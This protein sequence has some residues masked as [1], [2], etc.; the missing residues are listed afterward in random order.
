[1]NKGLISGLVLLSIGLV[2]GILLS[3]VNYFTAPIIKE[4]EDQIKYEAL[5]E[6]YT[7][8]DYDISEVEGTDAFGT[9]FV[10]KEKGT[11]NIEAI[12]YTV[13]AQGYSD[14]TK[15]EMLI[16]VNN[17][18]SVQDYKV[19][20]HQETTGFGADIVDNDF[21]VSEIDDLGSFDAVAGVTKTS[22]AI[23]QCFTLVSERIVADL[24][25]GLD[26]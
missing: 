1:M 20:T 16:A 18:L 17:D 10:L 12:V 7:I 13:R 6:F 25:G 19:V 5:E 2:C 22:N 14:S 26:E 9:I 23:K 4:V 8:A 21:N 15:V 11:A 24:G 3:V